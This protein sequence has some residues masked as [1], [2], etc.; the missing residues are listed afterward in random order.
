M[1]LLL[2]F[3][4]TGR[5]EDKSFLYAKKIKW[6]IKIKKISYNEFLTTHAMHNVNVNVQLIT[7]N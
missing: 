6:T 3:S 7:S 1:F 4:R 5:R 2:Y